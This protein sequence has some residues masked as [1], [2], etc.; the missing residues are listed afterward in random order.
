[1]EASSAGKREYGGEKKDKSST[2]CIW[3]AGF[4]HGMAHSH[5]EG[6][7]KLMNCLFL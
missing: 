5:L 7:L 4:H 2:G 3:V 6:I 1:M